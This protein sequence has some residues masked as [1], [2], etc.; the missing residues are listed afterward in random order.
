MPVAAV[1][2]VATAFVLTGCVTSGGEP[3]PIQTSTPSATPALTPSPTSSSSPVTGPPPWSSL[4]LSA[5]GLGPLRIGAA[6]VESDPSTDIVVWDADGCPANTELLPGGMWVANYTDLHSRYSRPF[7]MVAD[8]DSRAL[9]VI[10]VYDDNGIN[11]DRGIHVGS[12]RADFLAAYPEAAAVGDEWSVYAVSGPASYLVVDIP[13]ADGGYDQ[14]DS[15][16]T[17]PVVD[18]AAT[19]Y[20]DSGLYGGHWISACDPSPEAG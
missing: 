18:M 6:P 14:A 7:Y 15:L 10:A 20:G 19:A 16:P 3:M 5:D 1:A 9:T 17:D 8:P 11:T 2:L 12:T 4:V 13:A